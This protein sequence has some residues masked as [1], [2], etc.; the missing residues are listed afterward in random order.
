MMKRLSTFFSMIFLCQYGMAQTNPKALD[1]IL[2]GYHLFS[3]IGKQYRLQPEVAH[4]FEKMKAYALQDGIEMEIV[5]SF[6]SYATQKKIWNRKFTRFTAEGMSAKMAIKKI[7]EYSTLPGTSRHHWGTDIDLVLKNHSIKGDILLDSLFHHNNAFEPLRLWMEKNAATF[8]FYMVYDRDS[9][10]KGF[11]YEPW[12]YSYKKIAGPY[13]AHYIQNNILR[14]IKKDS[15]VLGYE[16][17]DSLFL[18]QYMEEQILG[19][20]PQLK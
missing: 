19:I 17:M 11:Q 2:M 9:L 20:H 6:R 7:I 5:S 10:R 16:V 13:L 15:T 3:D 12:H 4:A 8:G 1:S 18:A 14:K